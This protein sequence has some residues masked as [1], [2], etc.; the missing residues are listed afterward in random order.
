M[1]A[2]HLESLSPYQFR[3]LNNQILYYCREIHSN[4]DNIDR[5]FTMATPIIKTAQLT[6]IN[7]LH[8]NRKCQFSR[9]SNMATFSVY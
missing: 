4:S 7:S 5:T 8:F 1:T 9:L 2:I 3:A 6:A